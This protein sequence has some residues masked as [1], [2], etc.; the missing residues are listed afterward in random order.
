M[1]IRSAFFKDQTL[2]EFDPDLYTLL[3]AEKKRQ[4]EGV[5]LIASENL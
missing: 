5:N 3:E 4:F 2:K 1:E